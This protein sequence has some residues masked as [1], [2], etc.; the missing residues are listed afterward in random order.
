MKWSGESRGWTMR[1]AVSVVMFV[2]ALVV[3]ARTQWVT[4][5]KADAPSAE[6]RAFAAVALGETQPDATSAEL[7]DAAVVRGEIS[8]ER[9]LLYGV[10]LACDANRLPAELRGQDAGPAMRNI[11]WEADVDWSSLSP[12]TRQALSEFFAGQA[13]DAGQP[14][15]QEIRQLADQGDVWWSAALRSAPSNPD[16]ATLAA[17]R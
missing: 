5:S 6:D 16:S 8:P 2:V 9:G 13:G 7:I 1:I 15:S 17:N 11:L 4:L 3:G 12:D 14:C 10:Y